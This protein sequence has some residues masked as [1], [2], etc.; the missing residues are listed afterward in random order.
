[1]KL[2]N[3][4]N[5]AARALVFLVL[6]VAL[7]PAAFSQTTG[8]DPAAQ[9]ALVT[10][11]DINGLKVLIKRR[12][13]SQTVAAGL[14]IRGGSGNLTPDNAG[15]ESFTLDV[16]TEGSGKFPRTALRREL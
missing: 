11:F 4:S 13:N 5:S 8:T 7:A 14:F 6:T 15:I 16:A 12:P 10:E 2:F 1:M 3:L 9:A